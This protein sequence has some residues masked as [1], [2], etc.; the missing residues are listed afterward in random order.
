MAYKTT[1][2]I[3][4]LARA[5][6]EQVSAYYRKL[7]DK[8]KRQRVKMLLDYMSRHEKH[9]EQCLTEY[10]QDASR[11]I[12]ETWFKYTPQFD[13]PSCF[14]DIELNPDMCID[15]VIELA[16]RLDD[17]LVELYKGMAEKAEYSDVKKVFTNLLEMEKHE[18][19]NLVRDAIELKE[20]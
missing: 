6:H 1:K 12:L 16:L 8:S 10:E 18:K 2:D 11:K 4:E 17:C 15:D 13:I 19:M 5:F 20:I 14:E 7:G 9:L 3:L